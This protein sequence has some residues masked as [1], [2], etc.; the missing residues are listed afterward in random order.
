[1]IVAEVYAAGEQPIEGVGRDALV[2]G[3]R[4]HGHRDV[5]ALASP[6]DL[7][8]MVAGMAGA[9]DMVVCLGAGNVTQWANALPQ[10]LAAILAPAGRAG[11]GA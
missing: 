2:D 5:R 9:G 7:A 6:D 4:A 1:V 11:A 8:G 3:L 10:Q